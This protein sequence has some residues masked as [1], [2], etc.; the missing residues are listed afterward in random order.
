MN[1]SLSVPGRMRRDLQQQ[2]PCGHGQ[3]ER[4][5]VWGPGLVHGV[6]THKGQ[7]SLWVSAQVQTM[8]CL[9]VS[10]FSRDVRS[11]GITMMGHQKKIL[12]SI[13]AMRSQ[14]LNTNGPKRHL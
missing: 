10:L 9:T 7:V 12:S 8:G 6:H 3:A 4:R 5:W 2:Q 1:G 14:L 11:L 13:Q